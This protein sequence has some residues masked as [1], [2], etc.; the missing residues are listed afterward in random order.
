MIFIANL[1]VLGIFAVIFWVIKSAFALKVGLPFC[2]GGLFGCTIYQIAHRL[3]YGYWF[4]SP[5]IIEPAALPA[6]DA[7]RSSGKDGR[8]DG[9]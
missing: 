5:D 1:A 8:K 3:R 4:D 9:T 7:P 2:F 6:L